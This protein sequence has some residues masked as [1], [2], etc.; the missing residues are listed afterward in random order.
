MFHVKNIQEIGIDLPHPAWNLA[1]LITKAES[2][3][4]GE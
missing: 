4:A 2:L 3:E 1:F